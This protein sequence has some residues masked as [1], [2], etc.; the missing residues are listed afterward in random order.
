MASGG[1]GAR[2]VN[3]RGSGVLRDRCGDRCQGNRLRSF[4]GLRAPPPRRSQ[5]PPTPGFAQARSLV[6]SLK[7]LRLPPD[8][9]LLSGP[10]DWREREAEEG[11]S[12][13][14]ARQAQAGRGTCHALRLS[15]PQ[16]PPLDAE[17]MTN[18]THADVNT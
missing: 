16:F 18:I 15:G 2:A 6:L 1:A 11:A 7:P 17:R 10:G 12:C 13:A 8:P 14:E 9:S 5:P 3:L 4:A